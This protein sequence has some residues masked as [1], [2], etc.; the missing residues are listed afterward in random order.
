LKGL[1]KLDTLGLNRT[2]ITDAGL[3]YLKNLPK[4]RSLQAVDTQMTE[5][6]INDLKAA[7]PKLRVQIQPRA[8]RKIASEK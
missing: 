6:G 2:H 8:G 1:T 3:R 4:L 7:Q 5:S